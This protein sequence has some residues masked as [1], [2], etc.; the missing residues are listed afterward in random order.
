MKNLIVI[1]LLFFS[2][3][4]FSQPEE[5][6]SSRAQ[7]PKPKEEPNIF[8]LVV[9]ISKYKNIESLSYAHT[10]AMAFAN[11]LNSSPLQAEQVFE[12]YNEEATRA[13][14]MD[15]GFYRIKQMV[16]GNVIRE[17]D[18][19]I[20]YMSGHGGAFSESSKEG[21]SEESYFFPYDA[22][23][24]QDAG[25]S[26][27]IFEIKQYLEIWARKKRTVL[28][29]FDAC[30]S[31]TSDS[32]P[33]D[34]L[35][36]V[37]KI[38]EEKTGEVL[39]AASSGGYEAIET[40][41]FEH[42]L[43]T[44]YF[45]RGL[46]GEADGHAGGTQDGKISL[47]ELF[48]FSYKH[49]QDISDRD[50]IK[51]Q[52]PY[53]E[54]A[55][56]GQFKLT[57]VDAT[58]KATTDKAIE[59]KEVYKQY[60]ARAA[61]SKGVT[62]EK[63]LQSLANKFKRALEQNR[64]IKP[65]TTS[66][67]YYFRQMEKR[68][69][70][71]PELDEFRSS[72]LAA[73]YEASRKVLENDLKGFRLYMRPSKIDSIAKSGGYDLS[74][75]SNPI[76]WLE[77][78]DA[79]KNDKN[80]IE[81]EK[82]RLYFK[83][84]NDWLIYENEDR[85]E[86]YLKHLNMSLEIFAKATET[87]PK[88]PYLLEGY[89]VSLTAAVDE[90]GKEAD[91]EKVKS[92]VAKVRKLAPKWSYP[93]STMGELYYY[94]HNDKEAEKWNEAAI[95]INSND[96]LPY[97]TIGHLHYDKDTPEEYAKALAYYKKAYAIDS[98]LL[99]TIL[100]LARTYE[101]QWDTE[102]AAT[103]YEKIFT[104]DAN[105]VEAMESYASML[106][107]SDE[108]DTERAVL[109]LNKILQIDP[110]NDWALYFLADALNDLER[111][112]EAEI[113]IRKACQIAPDDYTNWILLAQIQLDQ[114]NLND[115]KETCKKLITKF[116][117]KPLAYS[118]MAE[119][120]EKQGGWLKAKEYFRKA[121]KIDQDVDYLKNLGTLF[122]ETHSNEPD[123]LLK[124][125]M[126]IVDLEPALADNY[127]HVASI[128]YDLR[129]YH[130]SLLWNEK[131]TK[132]DSNYFIGQYNLGMSYVGLNDFG[133]ARKAF[134]K[135]QLLNS[136]D[137]DASYYVGFAD[138]K[139]GNHKAAIRNY[140]IA[141][142]INSKYAAAYS[143]NS[144]CFKELGDNKEARSQ[145]LTLLGLDLNSYT[146]LYDL[147]ISFEDMGDFENAKSAFLKA[148]QLNST[149][150]FVFYHLG[151]ANINLENFDE[152]AQSFLRAIAIDSTYSESYYRL[153][154]MYGTYMNNT[155]AHDT[156]MRKALGVYKKN[157]Q[158]DPQSADNLVF[159][160]EAHQRLKE[161]D[162]AL[163]FLDKTDAID[164]KNS[165]SHL[166]RGY[167]HLYQKRYADAEREF[168]LALEFSSENPKRFYNLA[169]MY[170]VKGDKS[171]SMQWL[172]KA[173]EKGFNEFVLLK[174]NPDLRTI[175]GTQEYEALLRKYVR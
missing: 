72:L 26:I 134:L 97:L 162:L 41:E 20:V 153:A 156:Y 87:F 71:A 135:A 129:K 141:L 79:L 143:G 74:Y 154:V 25:S 11:F 163:S 128:Y 104:M 56:L 103:Y 161:Y 106:T 30:R 157:S 171:Q 131:A 117:E 172:E 122:D 22:N 58:L 139:L 99:V 38:L 6:S 67:L 90:Y 113:H 146:S 59:P 94:T 133:N 88:E 36:R 61:K 167:I 73:L 100:H 91:I 144:L 69:P 86:L 124:V 83:G 148:K 155:S 2:L 4:T 118:L 70:D 112:P 102:T 15:E 160:G 108:A 127:C 165:L 147:G 80:N 52:E 5:D 62:T 96:P 1:L 23:S 65:D 93:Y 60:K 10:D 8:A 42:G 29:I 32:M 109:L 136:T 92:L 159:C 120:H 37:S 28:F 45:L 174:Y 50:L 3:N 84:R 101:K 68:K 114:G 55:N 81:T 115:A 76:K 89:A 95:R 85:R 75:Y 137:A 49:V 145:L 130:E 152:A 51:F 166:T 13:R 7:K 66:A 169:C 43:F 138:H 35:K 47:K 64:L 158:I 17:N 132:V 107:D 34:A 24:T 151:L 40:G 149:G 78:Y 57:K 123:S 44:Y 82:M 48:E 119:A 46:Y 116:P 77:L 175:R 98:T 12:F 140:A 110:N 18:I 63:I 9:G 168:K 126:K 54:Y 14:I 19:I 125:R 170:S 111:R 150:V 21:G 173:L 39:F 142:K 53:V 27:M 164:P 121:F 16:E 33:K 105:F 31:A